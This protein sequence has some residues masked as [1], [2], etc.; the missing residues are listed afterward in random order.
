MGFALVTAVG[1]GRLLASL[2]SGVPAFIV[3]QLTGMLLALL[4]APPD[5]AK[6]A[7]FP[8]YER[9]ERRFVVGSLACQPR[10][11]QRFRGSF[12]RVH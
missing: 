6:D 9:R 3:A 4:A 10:E 11:L 7:V 8:G 5:A 12:W 1:W 2:L